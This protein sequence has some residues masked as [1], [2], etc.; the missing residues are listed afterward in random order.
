LARLIV[1]RFDEPDESFDADDVR[2]DTIALGDV[3]IGLTRH[4]PG[5]RWS[6]HVKP[7]VGTE[8]CRVRHAGVVLEGRLGVRTDEGEER[9]I[10]P[11]DAYLIPPG[12]DSWVVG[13]Q[14]FVV[15]EWSGVDEW[16]RPMASRRVMASLVM[17]DI[18]DSTG[19]VQRLGDHRW[20]PLL[21]AH[22]ETLRAIVQRTKGREIKATGDG[23]LVAY[24]GAVRAIRAAAR[25]RDAAA[26]LGLTIRTA[27]HAGE[28][29]MAADDVHGIAVHETAR[30]LGLAGPGEVL[31]SDV[32]RLLA[33]GG[34]LT[35]SERGRHRLKGFDEKI[36]LYA[37]DE[38]G[39]RER[40][41]G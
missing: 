32:T 5:W 34:G 40:T 33:M 13:D 2:T 24:D 4:Q 37:L 1:R 19:H 12:H 21:A 17:T 16:L 3:K 38:S 31:V 28:V 27:V 7:L 6:T 39:S 15:V 36:S 18:V 23:F 11:G 8:S 35:F 30:I 9:T 41:L 26:E 14:Q 10:G 22:D 20:R 25:M 29:E